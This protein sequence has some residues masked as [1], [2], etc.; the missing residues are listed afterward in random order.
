MTMPDPAES[1]LE[2][3]SR[4]S[5]G[6]RQGAVELGK[7]YFPFKSKISA[8][9]K[10]ISYTR[11]VEI[12]ERD[13]YRCRYFGDRLMFPGVLLLVEKEL[14][15]CF[16]VHK[17]YRVAES[18][19]IY[20]TLWP[21][22]DHMESVASGIKNA[23]DIGNLITTSTYRNTQKMHWSIKDMDWRDRG[24]PSADDTWDGLVGWFREYMGR[25]T[26]SELWDYRNLRAWCAAIRLAP[27]ALKH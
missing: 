2:I 12:F 16:P 25:T 20:W 7:L 6:N 24:L 10:R 1:L 15:E 26:S 21:V 11:Q 13:K 4:L 18:H 9:R 23:G 17:N 5:E 14:A 22:V 8:G 27:A 19:P 3:L